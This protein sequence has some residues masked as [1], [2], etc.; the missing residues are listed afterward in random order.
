M[1]L[2]AQY[3]LLLMQVD[4]S[5][6]DMKGRNALHF[7]AMNGHSPM[8]GALER[9]CIFHLMYLFPSTLIS[10]S[11]YVYIYTHIYEITFLFMAFYDRKSVKLIYTLT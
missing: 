4:A 11:I 2:D 3:Y 7:A 5:V 10:I 8:L 6:C 1:I 9:V